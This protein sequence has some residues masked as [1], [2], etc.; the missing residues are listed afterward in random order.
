MAVY[1]RTVHFHEV[2]AAGI[3]FY[4]NFLLF[5]HE[6]MESFF[7]GLSDG[8]A[9]MIMSRRVGLPAVRVE[10]NHFA[11]ARFG[12]RLEITTCVEELGQRSAKFRH[13]MRRAEVLLASVWITVVTTNLKAMKSCEM[14][15]D[16]RAIMEGA[17][18]PSSKKPR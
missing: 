15:A 6:A 2:D 14:P 9:G 4:P 17:L 7:D 5:A 8:Y 16:V 12:E 1:E 18:A 13:D 11:P 3:A 10:V